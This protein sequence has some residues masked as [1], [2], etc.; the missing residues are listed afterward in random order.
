MI[1]LPH[2]FPSLEPYDKIDLLLKNRL[3][4]TRLVRESQCT[5]FF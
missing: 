2:G 1:F 5:V 3:E 4:Y